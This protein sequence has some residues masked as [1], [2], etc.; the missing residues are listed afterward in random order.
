MGHRIRFQCGTLLAAQRDRWSRRYGQRHLKSLAYR[1]VTDLIVAALPYHLSGNRENSPFGSLLGPV[2]GCIGPTKPSW[3][4]QPLSTLVPRVSTSVIGSSTAQLSISSFCSERP[5]RIL[6]KASFHRFSAALSRFQTGLLET[7]EKNIQA[8]LTEKGL[9]FE[10]AGRY[11]PVPGL[12]V[13]GLV[14]CDDR[15]QPAFI[16]TGLS[17]HFFQ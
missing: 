5:L 3:S 16:V 15:F 2:P 12:L 11:A 13:V 17:V 1:D 9:P 7:P 10:C 4:R 6:V 14:L 8:I